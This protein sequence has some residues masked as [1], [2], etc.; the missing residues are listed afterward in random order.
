MRAPSSHPCV[1]VRVRV[2]ARVCVRVLVQV[3][4]ST[5]KMVASKFA[6]EG[7]TV[8]KEGSLDGVTIEKNLLIDNHYYAIA[9][10]ASLSKPA[11]LNPPAAKQEDF[12]KKFGISWKAALAKGLVFNAVDGCAKLGIDGDSMDKAWAG[13]KKAGDLVKFGG[14]FYAG[15]IPKSDLPAAKKEEKSSGFVQSLVLVVYALLGKP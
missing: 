13:A 4:E 2:Y 6:A 15:R 9:N 11:E 3:T 14:G 7:I 5:K 12:E 8:Y 1:R 10:K